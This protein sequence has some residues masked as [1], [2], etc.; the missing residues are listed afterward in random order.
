MEVAEE[1][2]GLGACDDQDDEHEEEEAVHVVDLAAPD[3][4]QHE[5][6]LDEDATEGEHASHDDPWDRLGVDRLVRNL[7]RNLVGPHRLLDR[8]LPEAEVGSDEG[9][10]D[11]HAEP[12]GEQRHQGEEGDGGRGPVVPEHQVQD[13][14]VGE[15]HPRT[16]HAGEKNVG[17][18][19]LS[20]KAL[21]DPGSH[22]TCRSAQ[23]DE[24][25]QGAGHEGASVGGREESEAGEDQ[26]D[27]GH[28]QQLRSRAEEHREKHSLPRRPLEASISECLEELR[29]C[30]TTT[31]PHLN[32]S[33]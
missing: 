11:G 3:A 1:N 33:P 14:E 23:A 30:E 19:L 31:L 4:V 7:P 5:E 26:G 28:A 9:E 22:I 15:D 2:C 21:V 32:T 16:E 10:R 13:E 8:R 29:F 12:E 18:P 6:E 20:A 17:L 25:H 24:E 27:G